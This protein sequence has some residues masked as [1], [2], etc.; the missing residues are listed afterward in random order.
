L[1]SFVFIEVKL[2]VDGSKEPIEDL[3]IVLFV[4]VSGSARVAS[5]FSF[6][7]VGPL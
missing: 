4:K 5:L 3:F 6:A 1:S 7:S 2:P